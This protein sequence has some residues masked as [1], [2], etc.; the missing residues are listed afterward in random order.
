MIDVDHDRPVCS[1]MITHSSRRSLLMVSTILRDRARQ[2]TVEL[3]VLKG[4]TDPLIRWILFDR[5]QRAQGTLAVLV[6]VNA[7]T[8]FVA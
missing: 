1:I 8:N 6:N 4:S 5:S 2:F 7:G 3:S